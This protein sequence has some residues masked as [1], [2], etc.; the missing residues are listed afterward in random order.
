VTSRANTRRMLRKEAQR[1]A[2]SQVHDD[3]AEK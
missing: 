1:Y 3:L 2:R